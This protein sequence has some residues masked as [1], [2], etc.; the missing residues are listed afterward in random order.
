MDLY[1]HLHDLSQAIQ[2]PR[3]LKSEDGAF[4]HAVKEY[5]DILINDEKKSFQPGLETFSQRAE[6]VRTQ[7]Q[8][9]MNEFY[10]KCGAGFKAICE[11]LQ[12]QNEPVPQVSEENLAIFEDPEALMNAVENGSSI[13]QLLGFS[14][15]TLEQF[16]KALMS[17]FESQEYEKVQN[18]FFFLITISAQTADFWTG[19]GIAETKLKKY[20]KAKETF[21]HAIQLDP[22]SQ[23]AYLGYMHVCV[24]TNRLDDALNLCD[25]AITYVQSNSETPG[26]AELEMLL[27][28]AKSVLKT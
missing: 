6:K 24:L 25:E 5:T 21:M 27:I 3:T 13:Y 26:A 8:D 19:L 14:S 4:E 9:A 11:V 22:L 18:G 28:E 7:V 1:A 12:A 16:Y 20:E 2:K 15:E 10:E 17:L 23:D